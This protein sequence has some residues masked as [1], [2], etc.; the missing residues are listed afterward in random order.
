MTDTLTV[1]HPPVFAVDPGREKCGL[2]V[3][4]YTR[5]VLHQEIVDI[6]SL[7]IRVA[8]YLGRYGIERIVLG[9]R[10]GARDIRDTLRR[11]GFL[12]EIIFVD[13]DHSSEFGRRRFLLA[14]PGTGWRRFLPV[15]LREPDQPYDDYVAVILAERFFDGSRSTRQRR[16]RARKPV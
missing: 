3:V 1:T 10:T 8:H 5:Q 11:A 2:A 7:P 9:D 12:L 13:E 6:P 4:T 16:S 15:G 14:N